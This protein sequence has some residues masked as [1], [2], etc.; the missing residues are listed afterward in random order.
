L[1]AEVCVEEYFHG[2]EIVFLLEII[3]D[4]LFLRSLGV[5]DAAEGFVAIVSFRL[6]CAG[7]PPTLRSLGAGMPFCDPLPV[8]AKPLSPRGYA[9]E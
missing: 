7:V 1:R 4:K 2:L 9:A 8:A 3:L 6:C 5:K